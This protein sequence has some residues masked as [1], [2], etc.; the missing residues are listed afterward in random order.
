METLIEKLKDKTAFCD[1]HGIKDDKETVVILTP[2]DIKSLLSMA[3][4]N[5]RLREALED[6]VMVEES[7]RKMMEDVGLQTGLGDPNIPRLPWVIKAIEALKPA[8]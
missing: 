6:A 1:H 5:K 8:K 3:D 2:N 4:E 7:T